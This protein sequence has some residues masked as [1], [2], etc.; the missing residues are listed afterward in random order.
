MEDESR[1]K[2]READ[3]VCRGSLFNSVKIGYAESD[4]YVLTPGHSN[5]GDLIQSLLSSTKTL[6]P[7]LF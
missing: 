4:L 1:R 5:P 7:H 2:E 3:R 6:I